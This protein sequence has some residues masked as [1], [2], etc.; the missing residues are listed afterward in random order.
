MEERTLG[1]ERDSTGGVNVTLDAEAELDADDGV[2]LSRLASEPA[3]H[4][5]GR[6]HAHPDAWVGSAPTGAKPRSNQWYPM[7]VPSGRS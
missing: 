5:C 6:T 3:S 7:M 4:T 1:L 2:W